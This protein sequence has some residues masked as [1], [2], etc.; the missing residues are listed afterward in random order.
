MGR[1]QLEYAAGDVAHLLE[2]HDK[3]SGSCADWADKTGPRPSSPSCYSA[4]RVLRKPENAWNRV[5]DIRQLRGRSLAVGRSLAMWREKRAAAIDHPVRHVISDM[6]IVSI[7][8]A[9]PRTPAD[10]A[11]VRGVG[12]GM[13]RG[14]LGPPILAAVAEGLASDWKPPPP[15][16][17]PPGSMKRLRPAVGLMTAWVGQLARQQQIEPSLL[18]T[19]ADILALIRGDADARLTRGWRE[20]MV[21]API[22]QL[23]AG[24][25]A[26]AFDGNKLTLE[27]RSRR[28][29]P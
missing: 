10:L 1:P 7:A 23:M 14:R 3:L 27:E 16:R 18:A 5:K 8:Q 29:M 17:S 20:E 11:K 28:P 9:A 19:R 26:L 13:A 6:A 25:A 2:I 21:G 24:E 12:K 4:P 22:R 15:P